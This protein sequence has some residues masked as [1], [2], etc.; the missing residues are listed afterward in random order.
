MGLRNRVLVHLMALSIGCNWSMCLLLV[1]Q[2]LHVFADGSAIDSPRSFATPPI[3][4]S[5]AYILL[6]VCVPGH[7]LHTNGYSLLRY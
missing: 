2:T 5:A 1:S 6:A 4:N 3:R 7:T